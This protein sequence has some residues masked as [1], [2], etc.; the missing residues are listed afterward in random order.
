MNAFRNILLMTLVM[1]VLFISGCN[2]DDEGLDPK[3]LELVGV[4]QAK[5]ASLLFTV[6]G[7]SLY[8]YYLNQGLSEAEADEALNFLGGLIIQT[9]SG[10]IEFKNDKTYTANFGGE[11][12]TGSWVLLNEGTVLKMTESMTSE[13]TDAEIISIGATRLI[14]GYDESYTDDD[15]GEEIAINIELT[16]DKEG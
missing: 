8:Q 16:L 13:V 3:S 11:V 10:T 2:K 15:T 12:E 7:V 1:T 4:W 14:I 9:L 5:E 6:D